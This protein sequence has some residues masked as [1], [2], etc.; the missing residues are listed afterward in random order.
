MKTYRQ[1]GLEVVEYEPP[2][3]WKDPWLYILGVVY[4]LIPIGLVAEIMTLI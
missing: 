2:S 4:V 1:V 3:I